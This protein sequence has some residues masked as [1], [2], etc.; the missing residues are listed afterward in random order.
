[1]KKL[2]IAASIALSSIL[3]AHASFPT[4]IIIVAGNT[5]SGDKLAYEP[6]SVFIDRSGIVGDKARF[7][8]YAVI[9]KSGEVSANFGANTHWCRFGKVILDSRAIDQQAAFFT[10]QYS[11]IDVMKQPGWYTDTGYIVANS[12]ASRNLLKSICATNTSNNSY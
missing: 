7:F 9:K 3:P 1:M 11:G 12:P 2:L 10:K 4:N 6:S 8:N 5:S